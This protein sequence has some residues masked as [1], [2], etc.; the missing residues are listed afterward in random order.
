MSLPI[1]PSMQQAAI[2]ASLD[3]HNLIYGNAGSAKTVGPQGDD[4]A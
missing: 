1:T 4:R 2:L 3:Q